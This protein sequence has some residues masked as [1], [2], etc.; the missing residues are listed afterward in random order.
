M[1]AYSL[2]NNI[3]T[4]EVAE[5]GAELTSIRH[6]TMNTEYLWNADPTYWKRQAP[7]LFPIVGSLKNKTYTY[8]G[9]TYSLPQ[10]GFARDMKF[11]LT[12]QTETELWFSV[13]ETEET[14]KVYPFKFRLE[15]GYR[16]EENQV[17]A[18]WRVINTGND[19]LLFSIGG[20]PAF[21]CP[22]KP[23]EKQSEYY[24]LFDSDKPIHYLLVDE[25]GLVT[26]K[27][28]DNQHILTTEEGFL[29]IYTHLFDRD[30]LIIEENQFHRIS[31]ADSNKKPYLSVNFDAPL[32]GLWSP[33]KK[34]APFVCIEPWYGRC[35][36]SD[37]SGNLE[38]REYS[39]SIASGEIFDASYTIT[40]HEV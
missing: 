19:K 34:K 36:A 35:D 32:F 28:F 15:L 2:Q 9:Q 4:I 29:P 40:I 3:L 18:L 21:L 20:H 25:S 5:S 37:F 30:A 10:H 11:S 22:L 13:E 31:L 39:N 17:T 16:L 26:K 8:Q 33:A 6:T 7:I 24:I 38:E 12:S 27:P 14:M 23:S 1:S